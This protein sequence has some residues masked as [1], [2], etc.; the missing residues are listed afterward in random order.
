VAVG[1]A[2]VPP[3]SGMASDTDKIL[4]VIGMPTLRV[5]EAQAATG[6]TVFYYELIYSIASGPFG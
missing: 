4:E 5:A 1:R 2:C 6:A 3:G